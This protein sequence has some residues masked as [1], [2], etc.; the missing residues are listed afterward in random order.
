[1]SR[2]WRAGPGA[3]VLALLIVVV[4][5]SCRR[6]QAPAP[7][8]PPP[9]LGSV[10]LQTDPNPSDE[11]PAIDAATLTESVR[12]FIVT[13][14]LATAARADASMTGPVL[15]ILGRIG[16]EVIT[17]DKKGLCRVAVQLTLNT[18][19][20]DAP[21]AIAEDLSALGEERFDDG[22]GVNRS[23]LAQKLAQ[24]TALDLLGGL[25]A[26][27][28]LRRATPGELH[29]AIVGDGGIEFRQEALRIIGDRRL[30]AEAPTL[31]SLL[32]APD[33]PIRDAALGALISLRDQR[34]VS[35]L[36]RDRSFHDRREMMKI[37]D[38]I[39]SI[40][41]DEA[42][43]YLAFVAQS[44]DDQEIRDV[45]KAASERLQR[46]AATKPR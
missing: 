20:S 22:A 21:G 5:T 42:R 32:N 14:G 40:G 35:Q 28:R 27:T 45:A 34:A 44:H 8:P 3:G 39:A 13:S 29:A 17:A 10:E 36:T 16:T 23:Q 1:M 33:E 11:A 26:R 15:R 2:P 43:D 7:P 24:R 19:P 18:R 31:L 25:A 30:A 12:A 46:A 37:L 4:A 9:L 38:A 41:G 6:S